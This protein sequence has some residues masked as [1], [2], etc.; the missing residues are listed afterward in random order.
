MKETHEQRPVQSGE[1]EEAQP[2]HNGEARAHLE[3]KARPPVR[4]EV[5]RG[6]Q[7]Q[8]HRLQKAG[9]QHRGD[10]DNEK[11]QQ[12]RARVEA[13]HPSFDVALFHG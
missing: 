7:L 1:R 5:R 3:R 4:R 9:H 8:K 2:A 11:R 10:A 12:V 13:E 6:E